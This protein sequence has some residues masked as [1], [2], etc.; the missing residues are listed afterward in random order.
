MYDI[1]RIFSGYLLEHDY[2]RWVLLW[3][4]DH[5]RWESNP[6][7]WDWKPGDLDD[8][9]GCET[10][11]VIKNGRNLGMISNEFEFESRWT[12]KI[13]IISDP[14]IWNANEG[15]TL[16]VIYSRDTLLRQKKIFGLV[17]PVQGGPFICNSFTPFA[18]IFLGNNK[19]TKTHTNAFRWKWIKLFL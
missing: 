2:C 12:W 13:V 8:G 5:T 11:R 9:T 16:K 6:G 3:Y 19:L 10:F 1:P 18:W 15:P 4:M 14:A 17:A 7:P